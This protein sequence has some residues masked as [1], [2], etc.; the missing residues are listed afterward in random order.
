M[1]RITVISDT[2]TLHKKIEKDLPGGDLL[3]CAGDIS[4]RGYIGEIKNFCDW[5]NNLKNYE[6]K[7]F[8]AGNHDFGFEDSPA[9]IAETLLE[10]ANIHYLQDDL[11]IIGAEYQTSVKIWGSP[12][13]PEFC[14]WA[15]NLSRN[16]EELES[17]WDKISLNTDILVTHG[18]AWGHLD[19]VQGRT[20]H[21]GCELLTAKIEKIKPKIHIFG[22]I[23]SGYG[24]KFKNGTHFINASV[25]NEQYRYANIPLTFNWDENTNEIKFL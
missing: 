9:L 23:H 2:H 24:Y 20:E 3:I 17:V 22:H 7:I 11:A 8:I 25:L 18:P 15:F 12:W 13:Q 6:Y 1:I 19:V 4:S 16:G 21:L 10:Y 5:F 14:N